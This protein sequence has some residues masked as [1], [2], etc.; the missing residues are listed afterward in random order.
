M[1]GGIV[2]AR[3]QD[4]VAEPSNVD[5][6]EQARAAIAEANKDR[7]AAH[8]ERFLVRVRTSDGDEV[9]AAKA[10]L[11]VLD[12]QH[13]DAGRIIAWAKTLAT[14]PSGVSTSP[15]IN[16]RDVYADLEPLRARCIE[17]AEDL[18]TLPL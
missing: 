9:S 17:L 1:Y 4:V 10:V 5:R 2:V 14:A 16:P 13:R 12:K 11:E 18:L 7:Q 6:I 15:P 3:L 8:S